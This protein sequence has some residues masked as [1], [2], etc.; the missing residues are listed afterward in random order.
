MTSHI[1]SC[2]GGVQSTACLILA[3]QNVI[4]YRTFIFA[5]V[6]DKA[7]SPDTIRYI[8]EVLK[9]YAEQHGINWV[10]VYKKNRYKEAVDLYE[11]CMTNERSVSIPLHYQHG[12][13]G[14]RNCTSKWK[15]QPIAQWIRKNAPGCILGVEISTDEPQ[16]AK[17]ARD[18]DGYSKAYPLMDLGMSR[19]DCLILARENGFPQ[20]PKSSCWFC[21]YHTTN[22]WTIKR[23]EE[24][25]LF[26][27]AVELEQ[28]L[29]NRSV[30]LGKDPGYLSRHGKSLK[31]CIP[32]QLGLFPEWLDEQDSCESGYCMT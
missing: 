31:M 15:I 17:P 30:A 32:D 29:C 6:G 7:E 9:P 20:P 10:E 14:F 25:E 4:P 18:S 23:R 3:A 16:R 21:P 27:K 22:G 1:F 5:N 28:A 11:D 2:G 26:A 13:I 24:P 19:Q 8:A 12:G